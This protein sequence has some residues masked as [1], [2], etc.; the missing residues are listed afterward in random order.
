MRIL[1]TGASGNIGREVVAHLQAMNAVRVTIGARRGGDGAHEVVDFEHPQPLTG[2]Y[3][4]IFLMRPPHLTD[5]KLF[6]TFLDPIPRETRIV[7]LSVM[8]AGEKSF[9]PHAKIERVILDLGFPH[10]FVRPSYFMENLLGPL[11]GELKE[12]KRIYL[13]SG[14]MQLDWISARDVAAASV[15]ALTAKN[16]PSIIT[17]TTGNKWGFA[18]VSEILSDAL[19]TQ[20]TYQ[21]AP[22]L[23]YI[24]HLRKKQTKWPF[25]FVMLMLHFLPKFEKKSKT[26]G[27]QLRELLGREP[28]T[29]REFVVRHRNEFAQAIEK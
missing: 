12:N 10:H 20:I 26:S 11:F 24:W 23:G 29:L 25:V 4:A 6:Q 28:E 16:A 5:P 17:A 13:P 27:V 22:L 18:K 21:S 7:F 15:V 8:G 14:D 9:L 2:T 19:N 3:D 1:V